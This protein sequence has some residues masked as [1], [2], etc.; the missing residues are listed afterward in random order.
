MKR[1][2]TIIASVLALWVL[3]SFTLVMLEAGDTNLTTMS[4]VTSLLTSVIYA[5]FFVFFGRRRTPTT[6]APEAPAFDAGR[7]P[8]WPEATPAD[9]EEER[10]S[11]P[12]GSS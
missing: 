7:P 2:H 10:P 4:L 12:A 3:A 6:S 9:E 11:V 5:P 8:I 1:L